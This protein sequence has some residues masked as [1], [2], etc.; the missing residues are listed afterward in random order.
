MKRLR[1]RLFC[2]WNGVCPV[3]RVILRNFEGGSCVHCIREDHW[4][5]ERKHM[6]ALEKLQ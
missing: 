4:R 3:H 5:E 6:T 2:W 1:W